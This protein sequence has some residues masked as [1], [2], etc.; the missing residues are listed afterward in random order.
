MQLLVRPPN[1]CR[2]ES[3]GFQFL[4]F[5]TQRLAPAGQVEEDTGGRELGIVLLGGQCAVESS[6]GAW[7]EIGR[8]P[9]VFAGMPYAL[10]LPISTRYTL[11]AKT[12]CDIAFCYCRAEQVFPAAAGH[13]RGCG[14]GN[15][16]C[17]Q[18]HAPDQRH[19]QAGLSRAPVDRGG[20]LHAQRQL[21]QLPAAQA[22][23][24]QP[25]ARGRS[26][27]DSTTTAS[28][29]RKVSPFRRSTRRTGAWM[30]P[31]PSATAKWC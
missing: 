27:R 9:N 13:P 5:R 11:T 16:R 12:D 1:S 15:S 18:R 30:R 26:G 23:R 20:G 19:F 10:Y 8:R 14:R 17:R 7:T 29:V 4:E 25:S 3:Y 6:R 24:P 28:T 22:R 2:P 21:V 31:S